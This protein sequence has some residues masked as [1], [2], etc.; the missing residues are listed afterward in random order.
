MRTSATILPDTSHCI[1]LV[2][3]RPK[4]GGEGSGPHA[5][6]SRQ[7]WRG[8]GEKDAYICER[9]LWPTPNSLLAVKDVI[10]ISVDC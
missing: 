6:K 7:G 1:I 3:G 2:S 8:E 5:D 4:S 9:L 10:V